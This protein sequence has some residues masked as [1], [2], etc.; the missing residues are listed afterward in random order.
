MRAPVQTRNSPFITS[1][2]YFYCSLRTQDTSPLLEQFLTSRTLKAPNYTTRIS[3]STD[4]L[5]RL[6]LRCC[7]LFLSPWRNSPQWDR[8]SSLSR[9]HD[10]TQTHHTRVGLLWTSDQPDAKTST[11]QHT[12][13][14]KDRHPRPWRNSNPQPQQA[15]GR[16]QTP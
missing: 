6:L 3:R 9:F 12:T 13:L 7:I 2:H 5:P 10:H 11:W 15:S 8:A 1:V 4:R 14:T 16:R